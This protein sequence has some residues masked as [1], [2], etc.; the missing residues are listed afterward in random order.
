MSIS[1]RRLIGVTA[2]QVSA[3]QSSSGTMLCGTVLGVPNPPVFTYGL[4]CWGPRLRLARLV[5][6]CLL[7]YLPVLCLLSSSV[8][9]AGA[10][11]SP[12]R[13]VVIRWNTHSQAESADFPNN[14]KIVKH[15]LDKVKW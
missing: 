2:S 12:L 4:A 7:L 15:R 10:S 13:V 9:I 6:C 3:D 14:T 1:G 8:V 11:S 5:C